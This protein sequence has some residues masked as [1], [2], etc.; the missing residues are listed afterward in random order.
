MSPRLP[1]LNALRAF[2]AAARLSSISLAAKELNVTHGAISRQVRSLEEQL[3]VSLMSKE[4][5]GVKLT[6][7]GRYLRDACDEAFQRLGSA[8]YELQRRQEDQPFVLG[9][10]GSLLA[11]WI[12]PRLDQ[13]NRE[14]PQL[15][16]QLSAGQAEPDPRS[17]ALDASL[18]FAAPPWPTDMQVF[19]L[20]AERIGP[21][22]S[23][24]YPGFTQLSAHPSSLLKHPVLHTSSRP[25][26]WP[27]WCQAQQLATS[28]LQLGQGFEHLYFLLEAANAGLGVAIA[29][30]QLVAD[31]LQAGRLVAPW[32]FIET[33]AQLALWVAKGRDTQ[34]AQTLAQWLQNQLKT[35]HEAAFATAHQPAIT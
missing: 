32:G 12:I 8:C 25:Q 11:R 16:L 4:G 5:R 30:Q 13:L 24:R 10:P 6:D 26:A 3:G 31:D 34:R 1:S 29:P 2:A 22:V 17:P 35:P 23:P 7:S 19:S 14:L 15:G 9:C 27:Q 21:V 33:G 28:D 18:C 20:A